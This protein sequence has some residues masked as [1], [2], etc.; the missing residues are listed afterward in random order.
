LNKLRI[1]EK[2]QKENSTINALW[3]GTQLSAL[4]LLTIQSF[5][6]HGHRFVLWIYYDME[7]KI[8][9]DVQLKDANEIIPAN[10]IFRY[11]YKDQFGH[12]KGSLAGFSDIF[13]Y[14]LLYERGGWWVDMD[15]TCLKPLDFEEPYVFRPH[16]DMPVVGNMIKCPPKSELMKYCFERASIEVDEK[17]RDWHLPIQI[18][19]DGIEK[20]NLSGYIKNFTNPESFYELRKLIIYPIEIPEDWYAIHW[21]NEEWRRNNIDKGYCKTGSALYQLYAANKVELLEFGKRK[22]NKNFRKV[23]FPFA[24]VKSPLLAVRFLWNKYVA[25]KWGYVDYYLKKYFKSNR[26]K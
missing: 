7:T 18:L 2:I 1:L 3:I 10:K 17:N 13:R 22:A 14:K 19:N 11:K 20:Y 15:V 16:H 24:V 26:K 23:Y 25:G 8:P 21:I 9:S 4:E 12:G 5:L 6:S